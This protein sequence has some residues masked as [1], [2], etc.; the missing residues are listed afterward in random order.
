MGLGVFM[1]SFFAQ[2]FSVWTQLLLLVALLLTFIPPT[3]RF[4]GIICSVG[5]VLTPFLSMSPNLKAGAFPYPFEVLA[6][7]GLI[8]LLAF[9]VLNAIRQVFPLRP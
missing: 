5:F 8:W 2:A 6:P 9:F 7:S 3:R 1:L 4:L